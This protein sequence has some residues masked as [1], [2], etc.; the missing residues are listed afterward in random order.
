MYIWSLTLTHTTLPKLHILGLRL[1]MLKSTH[2]S[3]PLLICSLM[4][5]VIH[6][7]N[8][9]LNACLSGCYK[10]TFAGCSSFLQFASMKMTKML[11]WSS[12]IQSKNSLFLCTNQHPTTIP[13][14]N[15][16][17][18]LIAQFVNANMAVEFCEQIF[19]WSQGLTNDFH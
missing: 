7:L 3:C 17:A 9:T 4:T 12:F 13:F 11:G 18:N 19:L 5:D 10:I 8:S 14:F 15:V 6:V 16:L 2:G 1:L